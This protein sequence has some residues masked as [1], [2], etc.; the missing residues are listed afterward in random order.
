VVGTAKANRRRLEC[1]ARADS[2]TKALRGVHV[3]RALSLGTECRAINGKPCTHASGYAR[4]SPGARS[5]HA[6][7]ACAPSRAPSRTLARA[8]LLAPAARAIALQ[9]TGLRATP[10]RPPGVLG[11]LREDLSNME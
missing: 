7:C 1:N 2:A 8:P 10:T 9:A 6:P 3:A 11:S 5:S 4:A